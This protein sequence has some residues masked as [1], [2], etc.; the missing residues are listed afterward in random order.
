MG[1]RSRREFF[2]AY[3]EAIVLILDIIGGNV[4]WIK[5]RGMARRPGGGRGVPLSAGDREGEAEG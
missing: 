2:A 5:G 4:G 1:A 3:L